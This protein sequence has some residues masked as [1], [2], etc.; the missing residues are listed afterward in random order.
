MFNENPTQAVSAYRKAAFR[1]NQLGLGV[2]FYTKYP[3]LF[4]ILESY[5]ENVEILKSSHQSDDYPLLRE[6]LFLIDCYLK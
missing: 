4:Q 5:F 6:K 1:A 3:E 2:N